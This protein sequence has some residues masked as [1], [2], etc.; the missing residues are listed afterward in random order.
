MRHPGIGPGSPGLTPF[1]EIKNGWEPEM[2][3]TTQMAHKNK[4]P[5]R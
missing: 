1:P 5:I 3:T 4:N 2:L